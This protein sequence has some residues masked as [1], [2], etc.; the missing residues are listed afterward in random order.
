MISILSKF[1]KNLRNNQHI[2]INCILNIAINIRYMKVLLG[3]GEYVT[4]VCMF[5]LS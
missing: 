1:I 4:L 3:F 5:L 2:E